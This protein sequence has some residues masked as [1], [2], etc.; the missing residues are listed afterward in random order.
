MNTYAEIGA[1]HEHAYVEA[2]THS[3]THGQILEKCASLK[4]RTGTL[5][6]ILQ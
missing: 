1:Q 6:I 5:G 4:F 2:Q 3:G